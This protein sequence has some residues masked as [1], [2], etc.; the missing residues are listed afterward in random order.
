MT[1]NVFWFKYICAIGGCERFLAEIAKK[2]GIDH[3]IEI[4]YERG[5]SKQIERLSK[6]VRCRKWTKPQIIECEKFFANFNLEI[7]ADGYVKAKEYYFVV[8]A[9]FHKLGYKPNVASVEHL[10]PKFIAV[11][12]WARDKFIEFTGKPCDYIYNPLTLEP[13]EKVMHLVSA[14]RLDDRVKGG[15]RTRK[16]IQALDKYCEA[17]GRH[18][19]WTIFTNPTNETYI[20]KNVAI[21]PPRIDVRPYIQEADIVLQ[22]SNDMETYCY[23]TNEAWSYGVHTITTPLSVNK[24]LPIPKEANYVL[25]WDCSNIDD[26][27]RHIFEDELKPFTYKAPKDEWDK[28]LAKGEST[29]QKELKMKYTVRATKLFE[30][31]TD[32]QVGRTRKEGETWEVDKPRLDVLLTREGI[33]EVVGQVEEVEN[34]KKEQPKETKKAVRKTTKK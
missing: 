5:D 20:S 33:I 24:E 13:K 4:W 15:E 8:H 30:N 27:V 21:M 6:F 7:C 19:I 18:Y 3:D 10:N 26:V 16:L 31:I 22:L 17:T 29:Y 25:D 9:N 32:N 12:K 23:T 11:S 34:T 1:K 28:Y 2:Y 14:C